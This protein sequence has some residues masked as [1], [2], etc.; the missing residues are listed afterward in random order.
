MKVNIVLIEL[1][2]EKKLCRKYKEI[3]K[4]VASN[5]PPAP[6]SQHSARFISPLFILR[7]LLLLVLLTCS[8]FSLPLVALHCGPSEFALISRHSFI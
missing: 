5:A 8:L 2:P 1:F 7:L 3:K 4:C 6:G